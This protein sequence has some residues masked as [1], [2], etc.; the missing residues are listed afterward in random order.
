MV[1][2]VGFN[3]ELL[4]NCLEVMGKVGI[5]GGQDAFGAVVEVRTDKDI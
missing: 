4:L 3:G 1:I 5:T 2:M